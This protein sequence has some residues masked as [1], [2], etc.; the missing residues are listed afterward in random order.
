MTLETP[1]PSLSP[2]PAPANDLFRPYYKS[3]RH[4]SHEDALHS[5]DVFSSY[6]SYSSPHYT[7]Q[8]EQFDAES[9]GLK[10]RFETFAQ[11]QVDF[12]PPKHYYTVEE[13][14]GL[15]IYPNLMPPAVQSRLV[16]ETIEQYLPPKEHLN[17]LDLFYD[18]PRPFNLF[19][20][21]N[22]HAEIPHREGGKP[23]SRD[24]IKNKQLRWVTLGGQYNWTTKAYP[25]FIPGTEGFPYFP[26]NLYELLSRP[27]FSIN[28][29][30][31]I[32]NFYSPGDILSPHQDVAE[33]SQDD[34][35]S[36]SIGLDAIFYVG[37]NRYDDSENSLA[38]P[39]CLMLRSG[40]VI[41]MGG[42]SRHAYHGIGK[43]FSNTSPDLNSPYQDW[44]D[45][46]R[47][48]INVRQML[49]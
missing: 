28:P 30:A 15:L 5:P 48:N 35:V 23:T 41:V 29:E 26:K 14:P 25:S 31:A 18:I 7:I 37:L 22:P 32:I 19:N 12:A 47:V 39:L 4:I 40:D 46:K 17:N 9:V 44:L 3:H 6:K 16:T 45:T 36:V 38:P 1:R 33:L 2:S 21:E 49:Q 10:N 11:T 34:L 8:Q 20:N 24:K 27:L 42:K 13:L 43:V